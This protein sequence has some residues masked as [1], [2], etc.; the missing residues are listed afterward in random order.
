MFSRFND[1]I[2]CI[3]ILESALW[4]Q[5]FAS[6]VSIIGIEY[7]KHQIQNDYLFR[8]QTVII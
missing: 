4:I 6:V 8:S 7:N 2:L 1:C 5:W 3:L